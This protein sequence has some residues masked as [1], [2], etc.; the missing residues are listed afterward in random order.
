M[1]DVKLSS[2]E[3]VSYSSR[4]LFQDFF[5][6]IKPFQGSF[7]VASLFRLLTDILWLY[8]YYAM[9]QI[10]DFF[11]LYTPGE[12]LTPFWHTFTLLVIAAVIY[13][14]FH[15][16]AKY[17]GFYASERITLRAQV[18]ALRHIFS[19]DLSWH[20]KE[21]AGNK[22]KRIEKGAE[23]LRKLI[24]VWFGNVIEI[25]VNFVGMTWVLF[26]GDRTVGLCVLVFLLTYN[27]ISTFLLKKAKVISQKVDKKEE[28]LQ[29]LAFESL[30][31]I[32]TVKVL[33]MTPSLFR[34]VEE[35]VKEYIRLVCKRIGLFQ[36]RGAIIGM[37]AQSWFLFIVVVIIFGVVRGQYQIG[38]LVLFLG[39][40]R[41]MIESLNELAEVSQD[42]VVAKYGIGRM[43]AIVT[44]KIHI[45]NDKGKVNFPA[46]WKTISLQDVSFSYDTKPVLD[47]VSVEIHRGEK[48]GIVGLSGAGKS[49][50][51]KLLL[52]EIETYTGD[53]LIDGIPLKKIKRS[54]YFRYAAV[55]LQETE[56]FNFTLEQNIIMANE[57][58]EEAK[59]LLQRAIDTAHVSD[60]IDKLPDGVKTVI[61]EK[62]VKLSGGEKQRLGIAR[63]VFKEPQLLFLDEATS[64]LDLE[65]EEKIQ[66]SLQYFFQNVTAIVIAHRLTTIRQMDKIIVLEQGKILESGSFDELY[67]KKGRFFE[68]WE[69]QRL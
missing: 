48:I 54:D 50:L 28:E 2:S 11:T 13:H 47:H 5:A 16:L 62:G 40:F 61:G 8:P 19:L 59:N 56:V 4:Q 41:R 17:M 69:K 18:L 30:N 35:N 57:Q 24:R 43:Q 42:F 23:S 34:I 60:F 63:A 36:T 65:S 25:G 6:Y 45:D 22:L 27:I 68:L 51:F 7:W 52:K 49:T 14:I 29:G 33:G 21:N 26:S 53:I 66:D 37:W 38:F 55:V 39:Y 44:E 31:N 20:E 32:R 67:K 64:H 1:K 3:I 46:D 10:V 12:S 15:Y 9:A 58:K